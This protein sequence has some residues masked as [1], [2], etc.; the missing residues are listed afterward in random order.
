M[1]NAEHL[2]IDFETLGTRPNSVVLSLGAVKFTSMGIHDK[3]YW[4]FNVEGQLR[5]RRAVEASTIKWWTEQGEAASSVFDKC[6]LEGISCTEWAKDFRDWTR[7]NAD[8]RVWG[9]GATFDPVI[10]EN[11]L[12]SLRVPVP[13]KFWNIRC[14]RTM[15]ACFGI[16]KG[17]KREGTHHN[18]LDDSC[19]QAQNLI[20]F[21][22]ENPTANT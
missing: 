1:K 10:A 13:W 21:W 18:A 17:K 6:D 4:V 20:D 15:K 3:K 14:Y 11:I 22:K 16:E 9:N 7:N 8:I 2:M 19:F 5:A 12:D